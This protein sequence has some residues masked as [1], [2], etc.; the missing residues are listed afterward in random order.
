MASFHGPVEGSLD[1]RNRIIGRRIVPGSFRLDPF[2][3]MA[4]VQSL[5]SHSWIEELSKGREIVQCLLISLRRAMLLQPFKV[6]VEELH[7]GGVRTCRPSAAGHEFVVLAKSHLLVRPQIDLLAVEG[8]VPRLG[9][10][11]KKRF[12]LSHN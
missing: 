9:E 11:A 12:W 3:Q 8:D 5:Q 6:V 1:D 7:D 4:G 10:F 2:K